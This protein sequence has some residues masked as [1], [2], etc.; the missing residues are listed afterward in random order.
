MN[1][2]SSCVAKLQVPSE[3][4]AEPFPIQD[5]PYEIFCRVLGWLDRGPIP[6]VCSYWK[7]TIEDI[8]LWETQQ[9]VT[10][11]LMKLRTELISLNAC[12]G[13]SCAP[14]ARDSLQK[15]L[16]KIEA[17]LNS[18]DVKVT[19][20]MLELNRETID[21]IAEEWGCLPSKE[22]GDLL[23]HIIR[24]QGPYVPCLPTL[25]ELTLFFTNFHK[26]Q[27]DPQ[28]VEVFRTLIERGH[29]D[30]AFNII[31]RLELEITKMQAMQLI[32]QNPLSK[33][34][35]DKA[36]VIARGFKLDEGAF[37]FHNR[38]CVLIIICKYLKL[39]R[40]Q[41]DFV[42]MVVNEEI[43]SDHYK[44]SIISDMK[45]LKLTK[46]QVDALLAIIK[47]TSAPDTSSIWDKVVRNLCKRPLQAQQ[48]DVILKMI[49][50]AGEISQ[51]KVLKV[52][53]KSNGKLINRPQMDK[54]CEMLNTFSN[55]QREE[56]LRRIIWCNTDFE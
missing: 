6:L 33:E 50:S 40:K 14:Q 47:K 51:W 42:V 5:L 56:E 37:A 17:F 25:F 38:A 49:Q 53:F 2:I 4:P 13:A 11:H 23:G 45:K 36:L 21:Q 32:C 26:A 30:T 41:V 24:L 20:Q 9:E 29:L 15:H 3:L 34:R 31:S 28:R 35:I 7:S 44:L 12:L 8:T 18:E 46:K 48:I 43:K 22:L 16:L 19:P 39:S 27:I 52:L 1:N 10:T 54:V 55:E